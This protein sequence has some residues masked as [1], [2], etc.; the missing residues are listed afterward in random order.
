[1]RD[2]LA[3]ST[4]RPENEGVHDTSM[5]THNL[6]M[7]GDMPIAQPNTLTL[8]AY[9]NLAIERGAGKIEV[10]RRAIDVA[11]YLGAVICCPPRRLPARSS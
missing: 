4:E 3:N 8:L 10:V 1:M 9:L 6:S 5:G 7:I 2:V 11:T